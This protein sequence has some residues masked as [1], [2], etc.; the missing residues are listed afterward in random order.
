MILGPLYLLEWTRIN[1]LGMGGQIYVILLILSIAD[2]VKG[3]DDYLVFKIVRMY[4]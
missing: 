1:I 3:F 2:L 4:E